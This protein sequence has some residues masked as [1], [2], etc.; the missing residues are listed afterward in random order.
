MKVFISK[1]SLLA[2]IIF[3]L[4]LGLAFQIADDLLDITADSSDTGKPAGS[5]VRNDKKTL[6]AVV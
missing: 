2:I 5:D 4:H 3:A 6:P 1:I